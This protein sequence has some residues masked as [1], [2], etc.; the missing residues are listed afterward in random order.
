MISNMCRFSML[1]IDLQ[2]VVSKCLSII[3]LLESE[4]SRSLYVAQICCQICASYRV[5]W[6]ERD[7]E[8]RNEQREK[9]VNKHHR[10][11]ESTSFFFCRFAVTYT[12]KNDHFVSFVLST[13]RDW[14][15]LSS[16]FRFYYLTCL[17]FSVEL[18]LFVISFTF[19][20]VFVQLFFIYRLFSRSLR[21]HYFTLFFFID[22]HDAMIVK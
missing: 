1:S 18:F 14:L 9:I 3:C 4:S 2:R 19:S 8:S 10:K 22:D 15:C 16:R 7:A 13:R 11:Q 21:N 6:W 12:V 5:L 20:F 17:K